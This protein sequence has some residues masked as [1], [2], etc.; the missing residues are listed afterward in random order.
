M[1]FAALALMLFI[2]SC[3]S[4]TV[5][6]FCGAAR[7]IRPHDDDRMTAGTEAALLEH[8]KTG[9]DLCGWEP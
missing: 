4:G 8:N 1:R 5:R 3:Q 7:L 6:E 9:A 2:G